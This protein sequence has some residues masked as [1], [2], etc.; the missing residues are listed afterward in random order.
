MY[1]LGLSN[2]MVSTWQESDSW[3]TESHEQTTFST[4]YLAPSFCSSGFAIDVFRSHDQD[5]ASSRFFSLL[6]I[7]LI[8]KSTLE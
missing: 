2:V 6:R 1:F 8:I 4:M 3:V 5:V 7:V